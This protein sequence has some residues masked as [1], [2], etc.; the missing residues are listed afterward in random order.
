MKGKLI[1]TL[2]FLC[3]GTAMRAQQVSLDTA[4]RINDF[5]LRKPG[6]LV[7][8]TIN[9]TLDA[10]IPQKRI[11]EFFVEKISAAMLNLDSPNEAYYEYYLRLWGKPKLDA[12]LQ[13][14]AALKKWL[15]EDADPGT[16]SHLDDFYKHLKTLRGK[17]AEGDWY[18][19]NNNSIAGSAVVPLAK[20]T[21]GENAGSYILELRQENLFNKMMADLYNDT[22]PGTGFDKWTMGDYLRKEND[23]QALLDRVKAIRA[24]DV[25]AMTQ[26]DSLEM[27]A[28]TYNTDTDPVIKEIIGTDYFTNW[29]WLRAGEAVI[30]PFERKGKDTAAIKPGNRLLPRSRNTSLLKEASMADELLNKI[31]LSPDIKRDTRNI[32]YFRLSGT[33]VKEKKQA[34]EQ[35][36]RGDEQVKVNMHNTRANETLEL[37]IKDTVRHNGRNNTMNSIDEGIGI[38]GEAY[39]TFS[40]L[41]TFLTSA[42]TSGVTVKSDDKRA[43]YAGLNKMNDNIVDIKTVLALMEQDLKKKNEYNAYIASVASNHGS[44]TQYVEDGHIRSGKTDNYIRALLTAY[45][46]IY[47]RFVAL[48]DAAKK[49]SLAIAMTYGNVYESTL[50]PATAKVQSRSGKPVYRTEILT[51]EKLDEDYKVNYM[52]RGYVANGA[53]T[54]TLKLATFSTKNAKLK[55]MVPSAGLMFTIPDQSYAINKFE[56]SQ[57]TGAS[58]TTKRKTTSFVVGLNIYAKPINMLDNHWGHSKLCPWYSRLSV[59]IGLDV[60]EIMYHFYPGISYDILPGLKITGGAHLYRHTKYEIRNNAVQKQ[61][62]VLR[63]AGPFVGVNLDPNI[64]LRIVNLFNNK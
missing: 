26:A 41:T 20:T 27:V 23:L 18:K 22:Y 9:S 10:G 38:L 42:W 43:S 4:G 54:D 61:G 51:A 56:V 8:M 2:L 45:S 21:T 64:V 57:T 29:I 5:E 40:S 63:G 28:I 16:V 59:F 25:N 46:G 33:A 35:P 12:V 3:C 30:N 19:V 52:V 17:T 48:K 15:E 50:P 44:L 7:Q 13:E 47:N 24:K 6:K 32:H 55:W 11:A 34:I 58:I 39:K 37:V 53:K 49:D 62:D 14:L 1:L 31:L 60:P 36:L